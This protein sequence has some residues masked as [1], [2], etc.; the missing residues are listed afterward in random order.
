MNFKSEKSSSDSTT[1]PETSSAGIIKW[2]ALSVVLSNVFFVLIVVFLMRHS[3]L[4]YEHDASTEARNLAHTFADSLASDIDKID[5]A[6]RAVA[7]EC[8]RA[9]KKGGIDA[10]HMN[11]FLAGQQR[12]L[13]IVD[14]MWI[15]DDR[16]FVRYG[17][18]AAPASHA[19]ISSRDYFVKPRSDPKAGLF[20][21]GPELILTDNE[22]VLPLSR[23]LT[24]PDGSFGGVVFA[25][26]PIQY[27][28]S[29]FSHVDI[30]TL[31]GISLRDANMGI[32]ARH[33]APTDLGSII[34]NRT[35][36]PELRKLFEAGKTEGTFFTPTSWDNV[37]KVVSYHK[38]ADYPLFVNVGL[39]REDYLTEWRTEILKMSLLTALFLALTVISSRFIYRSMT[40]L[41]K[42]ADALREAH[43][44]LEQRVAERTT[45]MNSANEH[46][47]KE[48]A[49]RMKVEQ[50]L[51]LHVHQTPL[52][53]I[54]WDTDFHVTSWNPAAEKIFGYSAAEAM[55]CH[56]EFIVPAGAR[57]H[58][59]R[60]WSELLQRRGGERSTNDNVTKEGRTIQC[61][62]YNTPLITAAGTVIGVASL[63]QDVS[64]RVRAEESLRKSETELNESQ[65]LG[66][67]G[68][69]DWDAVNDAIW[70]SNE[71]YR[72]YGFDPS[73]PP[74][75]YEEHKKAYTQES[76]DRLDAAV[77]RAMETGEPYE[78]D[79]ELARPVE[80][81]RWIVARGEVKR[82]ASGKIW[83]LRGTAQNITARKRA[84]DELK[85]LSLRT[86]MI[87][88]EAGE[89][90]YGIDINGNITF[91]NSA[92]QNMLGYAEAEVLGKNSHR[93]FHHTKSDGSP[94]PA[95]ECPLHKSL[96]L[97]ESFRGPDEIFWTKDGRQFAVEHVNTP[98]V[99]NGSVIGAV[100][101]FRDI[102]ERK[103]SEDEIRKLNAE[104]ERRVTLR[105]SDL[106]KKSGELS[107]SQTAL[108]NIVEDLND[109]TA[110]LEAAYEKLKG[111]DL[112]KSLFIASMSHELRTPL[113][114]IIGFSSIMLNE[115]TGPLTQEQKDNLGSVLRSG[116]HLLSLINDVIDV[117]K[118]EAGKLESLE[119]E[120][121]V[122][123]VVAEA[124]QS[125]SA[126]FLKK[127]LTLDIRVGH[128]TLRADRRRLL[129]CMINLVSN[130][131]KYTDKGAVTISAAPSA[132][133]NSFEISV[134]DTG[135]GI[136]PDDREK[137]FT[138][139]FRIVKSKRA[140]VPGTG[141]GL[142]LTRKLAQEVLK[143]DILVSSAS[144]VG[145]T[146]VLTMPLATARRQP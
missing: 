54:E 105:T 121:D 68:S 74:P 24:R 66:Q 14:G 6:F 76:A 127:G 5:W 42:T 41:R 32:I 63:V 2:L 132:D 94:Y 44:E 57:P 40:E 71:Y 22:W 135:V 67:I 109:K 37:A 130:A 116:K 73:Q 69:W 10:R 98:L 143:G 26:I 18:G 25:R 58:V 99:E 79:L 131:V 92:A 39:A 86:E 7:D 27:F 133:G 78:L 128:H 136:E 3:H 45:E 124:V 80:S 141:L 43:G 104:L 117:S 20:I 46:L 87:L 123:D 139:F 110:E 51:A 75:N 91:M 15:A 126:D 12:C 77:K 120:F 122:A 35:L 134:N 52:A 145:S 36:S 62:W 129:Q 70:W 97:G 138:P 33:P 48:L 34:G 144:G 81:T 113:N 125:F 82:D 119:E 47:G 96:T 112:L 101:V 49:E 55:G 11:A 61:D 89:G 9:A 23:R 8:E 30:G 64:Y 59:D 118:I 65:R 60:I 137:L 111:L 114:S 21:G 85:R 50:R 102:T 19:S 53:V 29:Q 31:G 84:E 16:G 17:R 83:G 140:V 13:P 56:A 142:Y 90:I 72:I 1:V 146:F 93:L 103:Q 88:N 4:M 108:M 95:E 115:W 106:E 100:V 38:I 107:G 28:F